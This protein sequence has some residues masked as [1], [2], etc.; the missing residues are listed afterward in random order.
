MAEARAA[1]AP[2]NALPLQVVRLRHPSRWVAVGVVVLLLFLLVR[3][4]I[5]NE[6][7]QWDVVFGYLFTD[8]ILNGLGNTLIL[9][10]IRWSWG[11]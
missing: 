11:W 7:Y 2:S 9:T 4:L 8:S 3:T 6:R 1:P 10:V 5:T